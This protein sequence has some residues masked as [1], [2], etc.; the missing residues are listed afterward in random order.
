MRGA[1]ISSRALGQVDRPMFWCVVTFTGRRRVVSLIWVS[2]QSDGS[3]GWWRPPSYKTLLSP[4]LVLAPL[5]PYCDLGPDK[6]RW[7]RDCQTGRAG[8]EPL[9]GLSC[10][11]VLEGPMK[12]I[13]TYEERLRVS[14]GSPPPHLLRLQAPQCNCSLRYAPRTLWEIPRPLPETDWNDPSTLFQELISFMQLFWLV[15][16]HL[17]GASVNLE[18]KRDSPQL[19]VQN[20][21]LYSVVL[22]RKLDLS[23]KMSTLSSSYLNYFHLLSTYIWSL[24]DYRIISKQ[25][26]QA[27]YWLKFSPS[28]SK[29]EPQDNFHCGMCGFVVYVLSFI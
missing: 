4:P 7:K 16:H 1:I 5:R 22:L 10:D 29:L 21:C 9:W 2:D 17:S 12:G 28:V 18:P 23:A 25:N 20:V 11:T 26:R 8:L 15:I 3:W 24:D 13:L 19:R 14:L 6:D 27:G